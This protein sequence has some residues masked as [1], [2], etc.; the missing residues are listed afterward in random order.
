MWRD[1]VADICAEEIEDTAP[2]GIPLDICEQ[3]K[4]KLIF[5]DSLVYEIIALNNQKS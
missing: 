3:M 2:L 1:G 4:I 5:E